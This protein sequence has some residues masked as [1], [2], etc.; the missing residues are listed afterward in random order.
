MKNLPPAAIATIFIVSIEPRQCGL[1][2]NGG[3]VLFLDNSICYYY[4][5]IVSLHRSD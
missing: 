1:G 4:S 3:V 5:A 2:T